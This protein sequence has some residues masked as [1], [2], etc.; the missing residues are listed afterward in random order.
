MN[1]G[2]ASYSI[3]NIDSTGA[4][5]VTSIAFS[6]GNVPGPAPFCSLY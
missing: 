2:L 4:Q 6:I 5:R 1:G 3:D